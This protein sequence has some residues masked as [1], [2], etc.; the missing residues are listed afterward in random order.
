M[1]S[2]HASTESTSWILFVTACEALDDEDASLVDVQGRTKAQEADGHIGE[3][4]TAGGLLW[5]LSG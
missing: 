3:P 4:V 2:I 1:T 5:G